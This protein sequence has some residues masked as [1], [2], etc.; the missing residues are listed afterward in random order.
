MKDW[1]GQKLRRLAKTKRSFRYM[2]GEL[3]NM[4]PIELRVGDP[5]KQKHE[6]KDWVR[7]NIPEERKLDAG[8]SSDGDSETEDDTS[9][10]DNT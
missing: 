4:M 6:I 9:P 2:F 10:S 8:S 7:S 3:T 5:Q 1:E